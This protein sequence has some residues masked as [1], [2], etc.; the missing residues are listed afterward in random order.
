MEQGRSSG[1]NAYRVPNV[2]AILQ[3]EAGEKSR[4]AVK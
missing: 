2:P 1:I 3:L 4:S